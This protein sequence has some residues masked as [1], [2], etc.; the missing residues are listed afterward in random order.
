MFKKIV[1]HLKWCRRP[2]S[3]KSK[4]VIASS[5]AGKE[6]LDNN[7][8]LPNDYAQR[9]AFLQASKDTSTHYPHQRS[10]TTWMS[11]AA[12]HSTYTHLQPTQS[13]PTDIISITGR[14]SSLRS[15]GQHLFFV[16]VREGE[17]KMQVVLTLD[18]YINEA[19]FKRDING[20]QRGDLVEVHGM[21]HRTTAGE[22]SV[23]AIAMNR[24]TPCLINL[25]NERHP[26][27]AIDKIIR[28]RHLDLLSNPSKLQ[29]FRQR[30]KI[31][32]LIRSFMEREEYVEVE[33]PILSSQVGGAMATP[34]VISTSKFA[35]H[36]LYL[37]IAPE[38][39]LKQ[40]IVSGMRKVYELGK[41]FRNEGKCMP[42]ALIIH[43]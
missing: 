43:A 41:V 18:D 12:L 27:H 35:K 6:E 5:T 30:A 21:P 28:H 23:K 22:L 1:H 7:R 17:D 11:L 16:D 38:L 32:S 34:F 25:P 20:I 4:A 29:I 9:L 24:L 40:C 36:P 10:L 8:T 39:Y 14:V 15:S 13:L 19:C 33:T 2:Y 3:L 26:L 37:R 31:L 42:T